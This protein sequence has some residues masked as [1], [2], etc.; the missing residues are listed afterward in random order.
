MMISTK[1]AEQ[2]PNS[3]LGTGPIVN[4]FYAQ[5]QWDLFDNILVPSNN[6]SGSPIIHLRKIH[7]IHIGK[8]P[9]TIH[10]LLASEMNRPDGTR[11]RFARQCSSLG[12]S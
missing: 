4:D 6:L 12:D 7:G 5:S 11:D 10:R 2:S 9:A 1:E 8:G 3:N